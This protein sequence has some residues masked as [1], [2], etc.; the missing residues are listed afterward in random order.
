M[1]A[2]NSKWSASICKANRRKRPVYF[3]AA[4]DTPHGVVQQNAT[5]LCGWRIGKAQTPPKLTSIALEKYEEIRPTTTDPALG[6]KRAF[7]ECTEAVL[8]KND[9]YTRQLAYG[10]DHWFNNLE[11]AFGVHQGNQGLAIG[12]VN[13][14]GL[15]DVYVCQP[16][17]LPNRLFVQQT[18]G[19]LKDVSAAAGVDWLDMLAQR[20]VGRSR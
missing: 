3:Q 11:V 18:D 4:G 6:V 16:A 13:G 20:P 1:S 15:D 8:A 2:R 19:T 17:G 12:D 5:W 10:A 7:A 9:S 14:D